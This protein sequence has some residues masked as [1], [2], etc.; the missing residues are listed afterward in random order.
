MLGSSTL[1]LA[2]GTLLTMSSSTACGL[3]LG[4]GDE[5]CYHTS[6]TTLCSCLLPCGLLFVLD[7]EG[8][9]EHGRGLEKA[10][11][12]PPGCRLAQL[13]RKY[14]GKS[15]GNYLSFCQIICDASAT[16][17]GTFRGVHGVGVACTGLGE[18][19]LCTSA[20]RTQC[21]LGQSFV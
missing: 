17:R 19:F 1:R 7:N 12:L 14:P 13:C 21:Q 5:S 16:L 9:G 20:S 6:C 10:P 3:H 18:G 8:L 2:A 4:C 11:S 15:E